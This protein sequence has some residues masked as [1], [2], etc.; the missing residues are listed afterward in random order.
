MVLPLQ[1]LKA[2]GWKAEWAASVPPPRVRDFKLVVGERLD[3]P[4]VLGTWRRMRQHHRLAY[5]LDDD[6]WNVEVTNHHAYQAYSRLSVQDAVE[7]AC[8]A[9]DLVT[10]STEP[11]AEVL[12]RRTRHPNVRVLP[13]Y[14]PES[15]LALER[16]PPDP[17]H[18]TIGW[19][20]GASHTLD[21]AMIALA[22]RHAMNRDPSL[23]LHIVGSDFRPTFGHANARLTHWEP[24][25]LDYYPH[26]L[27]FD[28]GLAPIVA[29]EFNQSKSYLKALEYAACGIPCIASDFGPYRDFVIDGVT[30]FLV[31]PK[32]KDWKRAIRELAADADLRVSMGRKARELAAG[33]TI[34]GN[35][36]RWSEAYRQVLT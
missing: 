26:L 10:V 13:N 34:E 4:A 3:R 28:I 22:V 23:R 2:H 25:P 14:I 35:W 19:T 5:E 7:E 30:G 12:R 17:G 20:G 33:Y 16:K 27:D 8:V 21:V 15:V 31:G 18:V 36:W 32:E 29:S 6:V 11:L 9:S 24:E 1:Q